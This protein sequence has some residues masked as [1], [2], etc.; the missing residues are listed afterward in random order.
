M[1]VLK[2]SGSVYRVV[3]QLGPDDLSDL[4]PFAPVIATP[5][6]LKGQSVTNDRLWNDV[7][8]QCAELSEDVWSEINRA[9]R[10]QYDALR[11]ARPRGVNSHKGVNSK[12]GRRIDN[13]PKGGHFV[14]IDSE[15]V[16]IKHQIITKKVKWC[17]RKD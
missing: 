3:R 11:S 2:I 15:G 1:K 6:R 16:T 5:K 14:A 8:A 12:S 7:E 10:R 13:R 17:G 9:D 4:R